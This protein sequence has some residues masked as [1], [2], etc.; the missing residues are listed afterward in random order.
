MCVPIL[1]VPLRYIRAVAIWLQLPPSCLLIHGFKTH[2]PYPYHST[3]KW[4]W[5]GSYAFLVPVD[6]K[7]GGVTNPVTLEF[8][9]DRAYHLG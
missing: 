8:L 3:T 1:A 5:N 9:R 7:W 2:P 4:Y 6:W